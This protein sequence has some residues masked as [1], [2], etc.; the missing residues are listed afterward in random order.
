MYRIFSSRDMI[1]VEWKY[2]LCRCHV[3]LIN[4]FKLNYK[5]KLILRVSLK[6]NHSLMSHVLAFE[7][8]IK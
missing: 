7:R 5:V 4:S 3:I 2:K 8:C 1:K 6:K